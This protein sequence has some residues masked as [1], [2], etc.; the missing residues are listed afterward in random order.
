MA[1]D[2]SRKETESLP[3]SAKMMD[4]FRQELERRRLQATRPQAYEALM[5]KIVEI[6]GAFMGTECE[7]QGLKSLWLDAGLE[8]G[9][10]GS[11]ILSF[12]ESELARLLVQTTYSWH[13]LTKRL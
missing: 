8:G 10:V 9:I 1:M 2:K 4:F 11:V 7:L 5:M 6:W 12:N 13:P 3:D